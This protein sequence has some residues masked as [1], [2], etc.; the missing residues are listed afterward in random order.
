MTSLLAG[1]AQRLSAAVKAEREWGGVEAIATFGPR[2][3]PSFFALCSAMPHS[4]GIK[5]M[6]D[7]KHVQGERDGRRRLAENRFAGVF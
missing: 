5:Q 4:H 2:V 1:E 3:H 6:V 7:G